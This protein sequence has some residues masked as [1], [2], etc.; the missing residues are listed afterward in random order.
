MQKLLNFDVL[1]DSRN[2][3]YHTQ[4]IG[5]PAPD[6]PPAGSAMR[7]LAKDRS[8]LTEGASKTSEG[9]GAAVTS[10]TRSLPARVRWTDDPPDEVSIEFGG[11]LSA[12]VSAF[13][14]SAAANAK[15]WMPMTW[16]RRCGATGG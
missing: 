13:T 10:A 16:R 12:Q 14:I 3:S 8:L 6:E 15:S 1:T 7:R 11:P 4:V 9:V 5:S 2:G